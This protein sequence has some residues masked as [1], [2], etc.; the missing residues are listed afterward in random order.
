MP[1]PPNIQRPVHLKTSF[2]EDLRTWL[3]LHLWSET[4]QR[5]PR[6]AYQR[7]IVQLIREYKDR[8]EENQRAA[9]P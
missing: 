8:I 9:I 2:P 4:E 1:R 7:L 3:D 5:V 6:G